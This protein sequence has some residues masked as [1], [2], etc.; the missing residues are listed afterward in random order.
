MT[1][2]NTN[3]CRPQKA[4][5]PSTEEQHKLKVKRNCLTGALTLN[6][7]PSMCVL[8]HLQAKSISRM[9]F[10]FLVCKSQHP[11]RSWKELTLP[12]TQGKVNVN[13]WT[14]LGSSLTIE[15]T[16]THS[17]T[18][19]LRRSSKNN[20]WDL[21]KDASGWRASIAVT[22]RAESLLAD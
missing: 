8:N 22:G 3:K 15:Q 12:R 20:E 21:F 19:S 7:V 1:L 5:F 17:V 16:P 18:S 2:I 4:D 11:C 13:K 10:F 14:Q 6:K 9:C